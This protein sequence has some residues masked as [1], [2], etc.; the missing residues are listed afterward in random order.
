MCTRFLAPAIL[1]LAPTTPALGLLTCSPPSTTRARARRYFH[2]YRIDHVLGFFRIWELPADARTGL[3]GRFRPSA[4]LW[5]HELEGRGIWDFDRLCEPYVTQALLEREFGEDG[6]AAEVAARYFS[7]GHARRYRFR[8]Q[9]AS[10][11]ALAALRP[12]P[13]L[14]PELAEEVDRTR[15]GLLALRQNVVLLRDPEDPEKFYPVSE[16]CARGRAAAPHEPPRCF[17]EPD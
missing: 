3:L 13:G 5:R 12:R 17:V 10:E 6:L 11:A 16:P 4:A 7:E 14:P 1:L 9:Y 8:A 2:A 15:R